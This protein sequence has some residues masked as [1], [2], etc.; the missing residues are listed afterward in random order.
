MG[1]SPLISVVIPAYNQAEFLNAS[2]ESVLEQ[3]YPTVELLV[4][5]D[6]STD[7]TSQLL[8]QYEPLKNV[9]II[10]QENQGLSAAR[11][12]GIRAAQG[13][14]IALLDSDDLMRPDRLEKQYAAF[15]NHPEVDAIYTSVDLIDSDDHPIGSLRRKAIPQKNFLAEEFFRHQIPSPSTL[16]VK[17]DLFSSHLFDQEKRIGEDLE[18]TLRAAHHYTYFCL[19]SPLTSYRRHRE[20]LSEKLALLRKNELEIL[21]TYGAEH[22]CRCVDES[23]IC[24]KALH[25]GKILFVMQHYDDA[26]KQLRLSKAP[27]AF[28]Y[29]ANCHFEKENFTSAVDFYKRSLIQDAGNPAAWNNLG[30]A[31]LRLNKVTEADSCFSRA[32]TLRPAYLDPQMKTWTR[33]ELREDLLPYSRR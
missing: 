17:R 18:W 24:D 26:L 20:N 9:R 12:R 22:I 31:L 1:S 7:G 11:N 3:S 33:R 13:S 14:Y 5:N 28:F 27:L 16:L 4:V 32:L 10:N 30:V 25:K 29:Q 15:K 21:H 19:D 23:R 8:R 6:G 2:I